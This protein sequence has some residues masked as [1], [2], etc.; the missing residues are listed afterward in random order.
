MTQPYEILAFW[1]IHGLYDRD[2]IDK[3][4]EEFEK[5]YEDLAGQIS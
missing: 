2:K 1:K 4:I 3:L 5:D